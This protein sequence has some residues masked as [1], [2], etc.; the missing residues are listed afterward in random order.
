M[1][2]AG[3]ELITYYLEMTSPDQLRPARPPAEPFTVRRAQLAFPALNR[4]FYAEVGRAYSWMERLRW[5]DEQWLAWLERP[6][7]QTWI[8]YV[9]ETP[10]G[11]FELQKQSDAR[12]RHVDGS[13][14]SGDAVELVYFG[15][16][17]PFVGRGVGGAMLTEAIR[18][19][20]ALDAQRVWLHTCTEDHPAALPNYQ[21]RGFRIFDQKR[22]EK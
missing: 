12:N 11:Y 10:A 2:S 13:S 18:R 7:V 3:S 19:A 4:F 14:A 20:W 8:G 5:T 15:L 1:E 17:P 21:K 22:G 9:R 6:N 16:L